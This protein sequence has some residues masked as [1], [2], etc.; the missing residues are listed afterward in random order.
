MAFL[1]PA[2]TVSFDNEAFKIFLAVFSPG[3]VVLVVVVVVA[4][5]PEVVVVPP[6]EEI[7]NNEA[8]K[9]GN[10]NFFFIFHLMRGLGNK[11]SPPPFPFIDNSTM[12]RT[13]QQFQ[14]QSI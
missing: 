10:N 3:S 5:S 1:I 8:N 6:Q 13:K 14:N 2:S 7:A 9:R 11:P 12:I 4:G